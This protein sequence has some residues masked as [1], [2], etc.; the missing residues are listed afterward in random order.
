MLHTLSFFSIQIQ[1]T[2]EFV[3]QTETD[4]DMH[5][6]NSHFLFKPSHQIALSSQLSPENVSSYQLLQTGLL[7]H[8][9]WKSN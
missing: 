1:I 3:S 2:G 6:S 4:N 8:I 9:H 5:S 7:I